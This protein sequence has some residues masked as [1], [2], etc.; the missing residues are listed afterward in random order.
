M[1]ADKETP[2]E[3]TTI[4]SRENK[5]RRQETRASRCRNS[6]LY[7]FMHTSRETAIFGD[8]I[9]TKCEKE[10][11]NWR[12]KQN[13]TDFGRTLP[14]GSADAS[15]GQFGGG[16]VVDKRRKW[17]KKKTKKENKKNYIQKG[18]KKWY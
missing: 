14:W 11:E 6:A 4:P 17:Q 8:K 15:F 10:R 3:Y 16:G 9:T 2:L 12:R 7:Y 18:I 13:A 5:K 1:V